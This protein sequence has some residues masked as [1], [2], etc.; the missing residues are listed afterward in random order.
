MLLLLV[1]VVPVVVVLGDLG[2]EGLLV[3]EVWI[4]VGV[5][6]ET[7][8]CVEVWEP[9][10]VGT[11]AAKV[12]VG[13]IKRDR[14]NAKDSAHTMNNATQIRQWFNAFARNFAKTV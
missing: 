5:D 8:V 6:A 2:D 13:T 10:L 11:V 12:E 7:W 9:P 4:D 14:M 3:L 1:V